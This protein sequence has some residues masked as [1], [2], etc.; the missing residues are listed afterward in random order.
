VVQNI[1]YGDIEGVWTYIYYSYSVALGRA[2]GF[3]KY[4]TDTPNRIQMNVKHPETDYLRF[5]L[6]G[7]DANRYP[8]FN[9]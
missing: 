3:T 5:I 2:V 4:G 9:G 7:K 8:G 6:G 1:K